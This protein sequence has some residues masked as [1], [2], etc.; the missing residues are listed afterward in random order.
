MREDGGPRGRP[1]DASR[2]AAIRAA[3]LELLAETGYA[4]LTVEGVAARARA[5]KATIYRRW[6]GKAELVLST[7]RSLGDVAPAP[8]DT[9]SVRDDLVSLLSSLGL[10]LRGPLGT[11]TTAVIGE[12][13]GS[14]ELR[15]ALLDGPWRRVDEALTRVLRRAADRGE[16]PA[17]APGDLVRELVGSALVR[18]LV[19]T[20]E[21]VDE[22][23]VRTLVDR[24]LLPLLATGTSHTP[25][26]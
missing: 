20:G 21:P 8:P 3:V 13:A 16:V 9:G 19:F 5:G 1:R 25:N 22:P 2:D 15:A 4:G 6:P 17:G 18:R 11:V 7:V 14:P 26:G 24:A 23:F 12:I 10:A